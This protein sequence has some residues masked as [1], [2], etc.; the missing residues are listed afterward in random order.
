MSDEKY[1][2][3]EL[4]EMLA[5]KKKRLLSNINVMDY[6]VIICIVTVILFVI[7][8]LY[9]YYAKGIPPMSELMGYFFAFFGGELLAMAGIK[10]SK[11]RRDKG[12]DD[13]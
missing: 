4:E 11:H 3:K 13:Y 7:V 6:L 1:T 8:N 2:I 12:K 5:Y 9:Y 10:I